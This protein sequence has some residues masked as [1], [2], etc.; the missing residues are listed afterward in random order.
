M[1]A[2]YSLVSTPERAQRVHD[3]LRAASHDLGFDPNKI[4]VLSGEP[5]EGVE[6][7]EQHAKG[8]LFPLAAC[9]GIVGGFTGY[10]LTTLTQHVYPLNTGGM[11]ISPVWTNGIIVYELTMLGAILTTLVSLLITAK[12]PNWK[13]GSFSDPEIWTGKILV[14][15]QDPSDE[16]VANA[17]TDRMRQ[18]GATEIKRFDDSRA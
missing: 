1:K 10:L 8:L 17:I 9:G 13:A 7:S 4:V 14:G 15:V 6:F 5:I 2:V 11:A 12:L 16:R 3:A 18:A